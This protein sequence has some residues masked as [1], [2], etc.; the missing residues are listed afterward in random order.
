MLEVYL[1]KL[2]N[3]RTSRGRDLYPTATNHR[4]PHK[5]F[6]L[7][8]ILDLIAQGIIRDN[9]IEPSYELVDTWNGY[10]N[11]VMPIGKQSSMAYP[12][13]RLRNDG[14]WPLVT[15]K[16]YDPKIDYNVSSMAKCREIYAGAMLDEDLF[17]YMVLQDSREKLR[18]ILVKTYFNAQ[19]QPIVIQ[20]GI[21]NS[22]SYDYAQALVGKAAEQ[23]GLFEKMPEEEKKPI[24]DAGFRKSIVNL[25]DHRCAMCGIRMLTPEGHTVVEAAHVVPWHDSHDDKPTNGL[26][27]CRLC[28]WSFDEGLMSVGKQ[29]EVL[30]S[31]RVRLNN[32]IPAHILPLADRQI[33]TPKEDV[34]WPAQ[35]NL[36]HHRQE[37]FVL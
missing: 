14:F 30:V 8:S 29:Y 4:A 12:F 36:Q 37:V 17:Q 6:L 32:N 13:P 20:Q 18:T 26:C 35:S 31:G 9:F 23:I 7:L 34:F 2:S 25:Y 3:L 1:K 11:A 19:T 10:W 16:G 28:H 5:P 21:V 15:N 27:L 24:R 33:F 22:V